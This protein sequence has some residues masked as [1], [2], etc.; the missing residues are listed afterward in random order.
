M[1]LDDK[2]SNLLS[3]LLQNKTKAPEQPRRSYMD[4]YLTPMPEF[5]KF[6]PEEDTDVLTTAAQP[7]PANIAKPIPKIPEEA[8]EE[9]DIPSMSSET[10][11][12]KPAAIE[13]FQADLNDQALQQAMQN[14][15]KLQSMALLSRSANEAAKGGIEAA[16][17]KPQDLTSLYN[18]MDEYAKGAP[19]EVLTRRKG[20]L[21]EEN[22]KQGKMES[23]E[24]Q[25][26]LAKA[27]PN[28]PI[29][30]AAQEFAIK[31]LNLPADYVQ[32]SSFSNLEKIIGPALQKANL[33]ESIA[34][35]K[36]IAQLSAAERA[37]A[38]E[39]KKSQLDA[40]SARKRDQFVASRL[41]S[42]QK[43]TN[44]AID[45]VNEKL[46]GVQGAE[47]LAILATK[48]PTA[49]AALGTKVAKAYGEVGA[50]T[51][52]DVTRY[53]QDPSLKAV[54]AQNF[55][56][57]SQGTLLPSTA[58]GLTE[59]LKALAAMDLDRRNAIIRGR[60]KQFGRNMSNSLG[61]PTSLNDSLQLLGYDEL[62]ADN[63]EDDQAL[64]IT[65]SSVKAAANNFPKTVRNPKT[66]QVAEVSNEQELKEAIEEGF[67][68]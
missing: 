67:T 15:R 59:T 48:N 68:K 37:A 55:R 22:L 2:F 34:A 66:G 61:T 35:R 26:A 11:Q 29:S 9:L 8:V 62:M 5:P 50:L 17:G 3:E 54:V 16:G 42:W 44:R 41:E 6:R 25:D 31:K 27:D 40:E 52:N 56:K 57:M 64:T 10:P 24:K 1:A 13:G 39:D 4:D 20:A 49:A 36:Q 43:E 18:A 63:E 51:E 28:S 60:A 23:V 30:K 65:K 53:V 19:D 21:E 32:N 7:K 14:Q 58:K 38:R 46:A 33:E 12:Y 45:K 47:Q